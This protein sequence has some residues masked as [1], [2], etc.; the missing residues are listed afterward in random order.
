MASARVKIYPAPHS[1]FHLALHLAVSR[2]GAEGKRRTLNIK[3]LTFGGAKE[4][5]SDL[6]LRNFIREMLVLT[7]IFKQINSHESLSE[8]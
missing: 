5:F 4:L 6:F 8:A 2:S 1:A 7:C 3:W